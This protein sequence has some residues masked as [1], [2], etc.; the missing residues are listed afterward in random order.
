[1]PSR[2]APLPPYRHDDDVIQPKSKDRGP[3]ARRLAQYPGTIAAPQEMNRPTLTARVEQPHVSSS[4]RINR[5]SL[6]AFAVV[7]E[8]AGEPKVGLSIRSADGRGNNVFDFQPALDE[9]LGTQTISAAIPCS[10]AHALADFDGYVP[11]AQGC[12]GSRRPRRTASRS[13]WALRNKPS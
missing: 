5:M 11:V 7:A 12:N 6:Y 9:A 10:L 13:A 1:M 8:P 3:A 2:G 4:N